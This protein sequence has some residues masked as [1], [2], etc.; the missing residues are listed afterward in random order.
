MQ[1][2][3][4]LSIEVIAPP[5]VWDTVA[6]V[7]IESGCTGVQLCDKPPRLVGYLPETESERVA[8]IQE[9][10]NRLPQ[11]DLPPVA[12]VQVQTITEKDWH[13][14]WR[15]HFRSRKFGQRLRVQP[16]WSKRKPEPNEQTILL[17]PGLAFGTGGHPTTALC[18]EMI[19]RWLQPGMR[20]LDM[21]T[22]TG[23]L[24]IACAK[25]GAARVLAIDNDPLS[26][27]IAQEN[28]M[29]NGV[30]ERVTVQLR[31]NW[32][33]LNE[34]FDFIACNIISTFHIANAPTLPPLL[35]PGGYYLASGVIGRNWREVRQ[36]IEKEG[37]TLVEFR[38]RRTW[39]ASLFQKSAS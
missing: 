24:A 29:R 17:D 8:A 13:T 34:T 36:A 32:N 16:S 25:L 26:V 12:A 20:V 21:G 18:L 39:T 4:W 31:D 23:I 28:V 11:F 19:D 3:R 33:D 38:K 10:L 15:R 27:Q 22:G 2:E 14:L 37:L 9:K 5:Q 6:A 7:M 30:S 1:D 35:A